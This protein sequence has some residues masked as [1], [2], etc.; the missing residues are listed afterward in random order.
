M[1]SDV[2]EVGEETVELS[3]SAEGRGGGGHFLPKCWSSQSGPTLGGGGPGGGGGSH[4]P[5]RYHCGN[6]KK[7]KEEDYLKRNVC[8]CFNFSTPPLQI[9]RTLS[10]NPLANGSVKLVFI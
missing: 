5:M 6:K 3:S 4:Q 8:P 10:N 9:Q 2:R 7:K 1:N